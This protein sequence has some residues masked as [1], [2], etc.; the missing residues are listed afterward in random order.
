MKAYCCK[1]ALPTVHLVQLKNI[2]VSC[3]SIRHTLHLFPI[4]YNK[5]GFL[6]VIVLRP[7]HMKKFINIRLSHLEPTAV[8]FPDLKLLTLN[9]KSMVFYFKTL[10][11]KISSRNVSIVMFCVYKI[12]ST[13]N[14]NID[15]INS[16][17]YMKPKSHSPFPHSPPP[18][19]PQKKKPNTH[20]QYN[21][22]GWQEL[23]L[24]NE[25]DSDSSFSVMKIHLE[26]QKSISSDACLHILT[27]E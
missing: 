5:R 15:M 25:K 2:M 14:T 6:Q 1:L 13:Y 10:D 17:Q 21:G 3:T 26:V 24:P 4:E 23:Q 12:N 18:P 27:C 8:C 20:T 22:E 9:Q 16:S 11:C 19:P 7:T